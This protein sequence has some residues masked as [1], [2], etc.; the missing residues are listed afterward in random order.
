MN[1]TVPAATTPSP[2]A[3]W[4]V[5][6]S[7]IRPFSAQETTTAS[8]S[9]DLERVQLGQGLFGGGRRG[10]RDD[11]EPG[12]IRHASTL[13]ANR[14]ASLR[15]ADVSACCGARPGQATIRGPMGPMSSQLVVAFALTSFAGALM[16]LHGIGVNLLERR[17]IRC[18]VCGGVANRTCTCDRR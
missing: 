13:S 3:I 18:R 1:P 2:D 11:H 16:F 5:C 10:A 17:P 12:L 14:G 15:S 4:C 8:R 6:F 9:L 7:W